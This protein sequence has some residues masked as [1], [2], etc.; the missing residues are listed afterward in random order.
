M[1]M[2]VLRII[3]KFKNLNFI[4]AH[5]PMEEKSEGE[6]DQFYE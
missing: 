6:K 4:Y 2:C 1:R 5:A 3:G